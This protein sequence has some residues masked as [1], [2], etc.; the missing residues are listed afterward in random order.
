MFPYHTV[1]ATSG[2]PV[3]LAEFRERFDD[4]V[5]PGEVLD[6]GTGGDSGVVVTVAGR[7]SSKRVASGKLAFVDMERNG[8]RLQAMANISRFADRAIY[9]ETTYVNAWCF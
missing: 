4:Y 6:G 7:V 3:S 5:G 1:F 8:K 2:D 9:T